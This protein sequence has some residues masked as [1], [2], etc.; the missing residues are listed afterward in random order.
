MLQVPSKV[1][2]SAPSNLINVH[3]VCVDVQLHVVLAHAEET[4]TCRPSDL[5]LILPLLGSEDRIRSALLVLDQLRL[6]GLS[7]EPALVEQ[8]VRGNPS[9]LRV[10]VALACLLYTSDAADE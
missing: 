7:E 3:T 8:V 10:A 9:T 5:L 6:S 1:L 2:D 4:L